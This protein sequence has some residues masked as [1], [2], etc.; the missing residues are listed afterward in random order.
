VA[1]VQRAVD[2][3]AVDG[4]QQHAAATRAATAETER[5]EAAAV[6]ATLEVARG[7]RSGHHCG[8]RRGDASGGEA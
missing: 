5:R 1:S 3:A 2:T 4:A 7:Q 6:Q 8:G